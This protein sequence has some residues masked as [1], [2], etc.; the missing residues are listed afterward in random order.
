MKD[1]NGHE[2]DSRGRFTS[3]QSQARKQLFDKVQFP[4]FTEAQNAMKD[5][6]IAQ[7]LGKKQSEIESKHGKVI[8]QS[9][10]RGESPLYD[11]FKKAVAH[12]QTNAEKYAGKSIGTVIY[13]AKIT[14]NGAFTTVAE[15]AKW[16]SQPAAQKWPEW[17]KVGAWVAN[18][19]DKDP[20]FR[21]IESFS[22]HQLHFR[23]GWN[24]EFEHVAKNYKPARV[25][26]FTAKEAVEFVGKTVIRKL[27]GGKFKVCGAGKSTEATWVSFDKCPYGVAEFMENYTFADGSPCGVLEVVE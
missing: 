19:K 15:F 22:A 3:A 18:C 20:I 21:K 9:T 10:P 4:A 25:R 23:D 13:G 1:R 16:L 2:H 8:F 5:E 6:T 26:P 14:Q 11:A 24:A 17:C 27:T 7:T 12:A